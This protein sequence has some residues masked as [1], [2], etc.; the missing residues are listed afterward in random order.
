[1]TYS[2]SADHNPPPFFRHDV[3]PATLNPQPQEMSAKSTLRP[4]ALRSVKIFAGFYPDPD[5]EFN[6]E[7]FYLPVEILLAIPSTEAMDFPVQQP[8]PPPKSAC[9]SNTYSY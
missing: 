4:V 2:V 3:D 1:M 9:L 7:D 6:T 5:I 8:Q